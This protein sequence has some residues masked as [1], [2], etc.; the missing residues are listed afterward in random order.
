M[1]DRYSRRC[2]PPSTTGTFPGAVQPYACAGRS[3]SKAPSAG[4]PGKGSEEAVTDHTCYDLA[5][6]TKVL[7]TTT[8]LALLIQRGRLKVDDRIDGILNELRDSAIGA[9]TVRQLLTH[10]S[11]LP[12]WRPCT[13]RLLPRSRRRSRIHGSPAACEAVTGY[14]ASE[15]EIYERGS[16]SI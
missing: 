8:A 7:A 12:G 9:A 3:S 10:S 6:L 13:E 15:I 14:I 4:C 11:G 16:R 1:N 5:S 2:K